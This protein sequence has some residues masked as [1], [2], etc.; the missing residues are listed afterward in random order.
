MAAG[1]AWPASFAVPKVSDSYSHYYKN[2]N[3]SNS[4]IN[5]NDCTKN[6]N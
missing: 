3:A 5:A 6:R 1:I 2:A 4:K